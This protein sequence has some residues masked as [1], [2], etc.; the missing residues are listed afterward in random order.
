MSGVP[1]PN[2]IYETV[3]SRIAD[4]ET[5]AAI[6]SSP[7]MPARRSVYDHMRADP[8]YAKRYANA[9]EV[10]ASHRIDEIENVNKRLAE[11]SI[12][13]QSARVLLQSLQWLASKEDSRRFSDKLLQEVTGKDGAPLG[14]SRMDDLELARWIAYQLRQGELQAGSLKVIE[15]SEVD[16]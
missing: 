5:L 4:G 2:G 10:R 12:D 11:G 13:P 14:Q 6:C 15:T 1:Y 8:D 7:G 9:V 3:L 16:T